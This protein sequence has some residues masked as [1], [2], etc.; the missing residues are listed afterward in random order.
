MS[1]VTPGEDA[2]KGLIIAGYI[3][4]IL[5]G[6]IGIV[7]GSSIA[8]GKVADASGEK[9]PRYSDGSRTHGKVILGI[10]I[11]MIVIGKVLTAE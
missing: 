9:V 2:G 6:L 10:G 7:L 5:G 3:F 1:D 8:F 11:T 4:A